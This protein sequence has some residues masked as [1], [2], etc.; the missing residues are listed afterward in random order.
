MQ[1][2]KEATQLRVELE[3]VEAETL[4]QRRLTTEQEELKQQQQQQRAEA[5][6]LRQQTPGQL[7]VVNEVTS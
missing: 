6:K 4:L 1:N 2:Q 3:T 5:E 7:A